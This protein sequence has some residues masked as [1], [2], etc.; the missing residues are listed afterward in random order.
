[1]R[2]SYSSSFLNFIMED[3]LM[4]SGVMRQDVC[5]VPG[6]IKNRDDSLSLCKQSVRTL[7]S[8]MSQGN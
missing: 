5:M 8:H 1:M 7:L 2:S 3:A 6:L 4:G